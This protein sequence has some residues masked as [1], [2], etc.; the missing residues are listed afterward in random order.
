MNQEYKIFKDFNDLG[1]F[2]KDRRKTKGL[3]LKEISKTILIKEDILITFEKGDIDIENFNSSTHLKGFLNTYIKFLN[4]DKICKLELSDT[5][6]ISNLEKSNL[7]LEM[8]MSKRNAYGSIIVLL[9]FI[10]IG[11]IYLIW[12]KSTYI[13][14]YFLGT[15]IK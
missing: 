1:N 4:L 13:N 15:S 12:S 8:S 3:S 11:S 14:L 6:K 9:S 5:K 2:L 7:Q 10:M